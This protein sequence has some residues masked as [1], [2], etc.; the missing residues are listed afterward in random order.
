MGPGCSHRP[1]D[2]QLMLT[3]EKYLFCDTQKFGLRSRLF[4]FWP[5]MP[6]SVEEQFH[7]HFR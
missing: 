1:A 3:S 7:A 4:V 6:A 5:T 2:A